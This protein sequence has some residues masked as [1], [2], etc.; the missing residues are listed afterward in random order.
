M[1]YGQTGDELCPGAISIFSPFRERPADRRTRGQPDNKQE[2]KKNR[3]PAASRNYILI[4]ATLVPAP[5]WSD[6]RT[7]E[8]TGLLMEGVTIPKGAMLTLVM[9]VT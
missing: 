6:P 5:F 4:K 1:H 7:N 2:K 8:I 9:S 3:A